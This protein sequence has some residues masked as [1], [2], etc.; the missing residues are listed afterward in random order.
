MEYGNIPIITVSVS[1]E[2]RFSASGM[3]IQRGAFCTGHAMGESAFSRWTHTATKRLPSGEGARVGMPWRA[4]HL[5]EDEDGREDEV[6]IEGPRTAKTSL[7]KQ[8]RSQ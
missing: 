6:K 1:I 4:C 7:T 2:G 8:R 3:T 5:G